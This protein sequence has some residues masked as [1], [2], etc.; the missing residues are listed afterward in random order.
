[1]KLCSVPS[2]SL[3]IDRLNRN[4]N[5][6]ECDGVMNATRDDDNKN[7]SDDEEEEE[8]DEEEGDR[9]EQ[10]EAHGGEEEGEEEEEERPVEEL[11]REFYQRRRRASALIMIAMLMQSFVLGSSVIVGDLALKQFPPQQD[12][13]AWNGIFA[14]ALSI[15]ASYY[16]GIEVFRPLIGAYPQ[17]EQP[18]ALMCVS[19]SPVGYAVAGAAVSANSVAVLYIAWVGILG[20]S[21]SFYDIWTRRD[22]LS[23]WVLDGKKNIGVCL[24]RTSAGVGAIF[25]TLYTGWVAVYA[26]LAVALYTVAAIQLILAI[27]LLYGIKVGW[28]AK[29]PPIKTFSKWLRMRR[30]DKEDEDKEVDDG[31]IESGDDDGVLTMYG[32]EIGTTGGVPVVLKNRF[33]AMRYPLVILEATASFIQALAG[34]STKLLL[35]SMFVLIFGLPE[36]TSAYLS[37][38]TLVAFLASSS[39][40]PYFFVDGRFSSAFLCSV[41][42]A[43]MT[44]AFSVVPSIIG[45]SDYTQA[46]FSWRL[47]GFILAKACVSFCF[48]TMQALIGSMGVDAMGSANLTV[49]F[50]Y[51]Y[52]FTAPSA[53]GGPIAA[54]LITFSR[55]YL[56]MPFAQ[57]FHLWF[58]ISAGTCALGFIV[59]SIL[60][61]ATEAYVRADRAYARR[62]LNEKSSSATPSIPSTLSATGDDGGDGDDHPL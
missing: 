2:H 16:I 53:A 46:A 6:Q 57:A 36:M 26:S 28:L 41:S 1:M 32:R 38:L 4:L 39:L 35:S 30:H 51:L 11:L 25:F 23:W 52:N 55:R 21:Y 50:I 20:V 31:K 34:Y 5:R 44:I 13:Y 37:A 49:L 22:V 33:E 8:E 9:E 40:I 59:C 29:P 18:I 54:W 42:F 24:V 47:F 19:L 43:I 15:A 14:V 56:G 27:P 45:S 61:C 3:S 17:M 10:V 62:A 58:Y 48:G 12:G 7:N 60:T